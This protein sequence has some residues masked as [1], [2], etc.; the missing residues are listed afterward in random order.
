MEQHQQAELA[1]YRMFRRFLASQ[2]EAGRSTSNSSKDTWQDVIPPTSTME[3]DSRPYL[4]MNESARTQPA[5]VTHTNCVLCCQ[6]PN[7]IGHK[8]EDCPII[9][10]HG[11][12]FPDSSVNQPPN[13][14]VSPTTEPPPS[15]TW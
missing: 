5:T 7:I 1:Q 4:A 13:G 15:P 9:M 14:S 6:P 2:E 11:L 3:E 12:R 10:Q 8:I